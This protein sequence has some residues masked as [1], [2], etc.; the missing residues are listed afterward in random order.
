M[1]LRA[2]AVVSDSTYFP[3]LWALLNSVKAYYDDEIRIFVFGNG[4]TAEQCLRIKFHALG[5][6]VTL[7]TDVGPYAH[8]PDG[9]WETKQ[10]TLDFLMGKAR[11]ICLLDADIV[12]LSRIDDVFNLAAQGRIVSS[13]D[14]DGLMNM[15]EE[16][17]CYSE[18][19][20][21]MTWPYFNSG[22]LCVD[23]VK[24]W[25]LAALWS[26]TSRFSA[27]SP[28]GGGPLKLCGHGDQGTLN[29][30]AAL[31]GKQNSLHLFDQELWCNSGASSHFAA[32]DILAR[33][34][35]RLSVHHRV[36]QQKQRLLHSSGPKWW[37]EEGRRHFRTLGCTL[38]CFEHFAGR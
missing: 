5:N 25:D 21:G 19:M 34:G 3:G 36:T 17:R 12:L 33:D 1:Y 9:T 26:F 13:R 20:V 38:E 31:L 16:Y 7:L 29:A 15:G 28:G 30:V 23:V 22:F 10:Q 18:N 14:G 37:T 27:Y 32:L 35:P 2:F 6:A 11:C 4:L 24:H 8:P